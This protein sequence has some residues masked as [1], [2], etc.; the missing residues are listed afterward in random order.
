MTR[1]GPAAAA[2]V[3]LSLVSPQVAAQVDKPRFV[4][5]LDNSTSMIANVSGLST[6]GDGSQS[7]PGCDLDGKSTGNWPYDDS[8]LYQAKVAIIDTISAFGSAEFALA[9]YARVCWGSPARR[10]ATVPPLWRAPRAWTCPTMP[11]HRSSVSSIWAPTTLSA[12]PARRLALDARTR[13][14][15][16][17]ASL[18]GPARLQH[19]LRLFQ[20]LPRGAGHCGIS[21]QWL[22]FSRYL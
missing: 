17:I 5:I 13:P 2:V 1:L 19:A 22:Q 7:Q 20:H 18:R 8:K 10:T 6:H 15:P 21:H 3:G 16:T 12:R 4:F 11:R 9:T 14:T